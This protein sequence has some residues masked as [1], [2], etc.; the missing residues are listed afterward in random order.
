MN[1]NEFKLNLQLFA[2]G[3]EN[4]DDN[5]PETFTKEEFEA[6]LKEVDDKYDGLCNP[7]NQLL[8]DSVTT[9]IETVT[10]HD[11]FRKD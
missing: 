9:F 10:S 8:F 1:E 5:K 6:K 11:I 2:E 4:K 7:I 3:D